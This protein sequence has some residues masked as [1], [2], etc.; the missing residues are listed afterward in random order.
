MRPWLREPLGWNDGASLRAQSRQ[1]G[2]KDQMN[3]EQTQIEIAEQE[4]YNSLT[5]KPMKVFK[6]KKI[7]YRLFTHLNF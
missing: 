5:K 3:L 2:K 4:K 6:L 7:Y 1:W